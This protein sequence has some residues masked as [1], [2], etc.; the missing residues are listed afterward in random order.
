M[1]DDQEA[2]RF[3][4]GGFGLAIVA[5]LLL[6]HGRPSAAIPVCAV[7]LGLCALALAA[8]VEVRLR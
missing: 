3:T 1:T 6:L 7:G 5:T 2:A 8:S 4:L